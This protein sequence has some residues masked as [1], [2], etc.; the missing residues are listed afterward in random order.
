M[1][2]NQDNFTAVAEGHS[3]APEILEAA[4]AA[5]VAAQLVTNGDSLIAARHACR[6]PS[7]R[8]SPAS[9]TA[10]GRTQAARRLQTTDAALCA[11]RFSQRL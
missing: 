9:L 2:Q 4:L 7:C 6:R 1:T 3:G 10:S 5:V 8:K 11:P